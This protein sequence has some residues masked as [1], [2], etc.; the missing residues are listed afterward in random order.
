MRFLS[1]LKKQI[2]LYPLFTDAKF[3]KYRVLFI[4]LVALV[5]AILVSV[6]VT[7]PQIFKL[8]DTFKT[9]DELSV[10]KTSLGQKVS[11]LEAVNIAEYRKN[12]DTALV[13]L[14]ADKDIPGVMSE[15]LVSLGGSGMKLNGITFSNSPVESDVAQEFTVTIDA[16]GSEASLKNFLE[17][18]TLAPRLIKL[19]S[20]NVGLSSGNNVNATVSF[21]TFYQTLPNTIGAVDEQLPKPGKEDTQILADIE[22]KIRQF[23][24]VPQEATA[25]TKGKLDPFKP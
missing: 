4:P 1:A 23:P 19:V 5:I 22:T 11:D 18:V 6:L 20:I 2:A 10:K 15:I 17:R 13:A 16:L 7:V 9:I 8:L 12:L 3:E 24:K 21:A 25:S 14:P